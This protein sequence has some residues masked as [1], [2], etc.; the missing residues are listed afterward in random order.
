LVPKANAKRRDAK[1]QYRSHAQRNVSEFRWITR[2]VREHQPVN[3][4]QTPL[5]RSGKRNAKEV[6]AAI[7]ET[8]NDVVLAAR[9]HHEQPRSGSGI[10]L[11]RGGRDIR[12]HATHI[13]KRLR[14]SRATSTVQAS[15]HSPQ[16]PKPL[17]DRARVDPFDGWN[18]LRLEPLP[19]ALSHQV[20]AGAIAVVRDHETLDLD[21]PR[22]ERPLGNS[23]ISL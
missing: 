10:T 17:R 14:L 8:T 5:P 4:F 13:K 20:V 19:K 18:A 21:S 16:P 11:L 22:F 6:S 2:T 7:D 15:L 1:I 3:G 9:I 23:I 12:H